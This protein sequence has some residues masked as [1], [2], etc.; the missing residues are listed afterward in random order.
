MQLPVWLT[1]LTAA[2]AAPLIK[3]K[4]GDAIAGKYIVK[5]KGDMSIQST[6]DIK[7]SVEAT[8]DHEY[9]MSG[10][11]G[12]AGSLSA[13]EVAQLQA[14]DD[15]E[16]I[17]EDAVVHTQAVVTQFNATWGLTRISHR[18]KGASSYLYDSS[19]GEGTCS[20]IIDTGIFVDHPDFQGRAEFLKDFSGEDSLVDGQGHGTHVAGTIGSATW[21]VAKK[22]KLFGV[23]VLD[24][25]GSGT[26]SG[27]LAGINFV[28]QDAAARQAE[29]PKGIVS[30]MSLGGNKAQAINDA[31]AALVAS[32]V[33]LAV[34]AGNAG[35]SAST[36]SP[37]S[38]PSVCT[39]GATDVFD[40]F[41]YFSN[42]GP[43]V[44]VNA[45]GVNITSTWN[46]G[47]VRTISGTSMASPHIAGLGAYLL[48]LGGDASGLCERIVE[49]STQ[50]K[51]SGL[52]SGTVDRLA[53][54]GVAETRRARRF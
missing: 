42:F 43:L 44:D 4:R 52:K 33:F 13:A 34:A 41:A 18:E 30:N 7:A 26:N 10:F 17:E 25:A 2:S 46:D 23:K 15:V 3:A 11:R 5:L 6:D 48:G 24:S 22:T 49:L 16:W 50:G 21:G 27:V 37:A 20:Y 51:I 53:F 29:C 40:A 14:L 1:L 12:W 54:N 38:E 19:A 47:G 9:T 32:G 31:A 8:P 28:Q 35:A 36:F 45:P 39:V